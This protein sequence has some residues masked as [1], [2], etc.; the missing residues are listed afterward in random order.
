MTSAARKLLDNALETLLEIYCDELDLAARTEFH[1]DPDSSVQHSMDLQKHL[2]KPSTLKK[3]AIEIAV[4][5]WDC[6]S[7]LHK[8]AKDQRDEL[9]ELRTQLLASQRTVIELQKQKL[10]EKSETVSEMKEVVKAELKSYSS[11]TS[12]GTSSTVSPTTAT[13]QIRKLVKT[14]VEV[15]ERS[16]NVIVFGLREN[17]ESGERTEDLVAEVCE[18]VGEKPRVLA[19]SRIGVKRDGATRPILVCLASAASA[20]QLL[21]RA[22]GLKDWEKYGRVFV[23]PDR[24][25]EERVVRK[26]L[27]E[28]LKK[29]REKEPGKS[30]IIRKNDVILK[31]S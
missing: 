4:R 29:L 19:C 28:E 10:Q 8:L 24:T 26:G 2:E 27:V 30:Y 25:R 7:D 31:E 21:Y 13:A 3:R 11:V 18:Q 23:G 1:C 20:Q 16:R 12:Q 22:K 9:D 15:E 14:T 6:T 17:N 5:L